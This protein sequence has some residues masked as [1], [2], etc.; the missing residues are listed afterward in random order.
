MCCFVISFFFFGLFSC[1]NLR[2]FCIFVFWLFLKTSADFKHTSNEIKNGSILIEWLW[3]SKFCFHWMSS[4]KN[5]EKSNQCFKTHFSIAWHHHKQNEQ[6]MQR[7]IL[8]RA[9]NLLSEKSGVSSSLS[10]KW[11]EKISDKYSEKW[12]HYHT[13]NHID[14]LLAFSN[15]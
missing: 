10:S 15:E 13:L 1:M 4:Q 2:I 8:Q 5:P 12:R 11:F 14:E 6:K 7:Q 3:V 9:W